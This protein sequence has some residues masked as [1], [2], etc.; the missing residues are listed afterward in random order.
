MTTHYQVHAVVVSHHSD[1]DR[2][3]IQ[4]D[5]LLPQVHTINWVDNGSPDSLR[6]LLPRWPV[7]R[8]EPI[9]LDEN[10][11]IGAAQNMGM[12]RALAQG[13]SHVLLM[14][15][16]S[17]PAPDMVRQLLSA[18]ARHPHAAAAGAC[19]ADPRR[20]I[21][22][23]PFN[24]VRWGRLH[25]LPCT[26]GRSIWEVD[27]LIASGCLISAPVFRRVGLMREDFFI[28]WVD[29]EWC[30]RARDHGYQLLGVCGAR[31]EHTLGDR[32]VRVLGREIPL[33]A[34]WRHYYQARNF[35]LML[36][37]RRVSPM[38]KASMA[39]RQFKRMV[40]FSTLIPDRGGYFKMWVKGL[41]DGIMARSGAVVL[42][43]SQ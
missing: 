22:R 33:H 23:T 2:L 30:L 43:D 4:F 15:D 5:R 34:P 39:W 27:H 38:L 36:R 13:A 31:L 21:E 12:Q 29:T 24:L 28:D 17:L 18:L 6:Q 10:L 37:A 9:W 19:H 26:N 3:A 8:V 7:G 14:D 25:W 1:P 41:A 20:G 16:D 11:G 42:P 35:I 32:V 40:V